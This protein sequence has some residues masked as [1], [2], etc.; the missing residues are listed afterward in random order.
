[1]RR[2]RK[3]AEEAEEAEEQHEADVT[4]VRDCVWD[5]DDEDDD[6][7]REGHER[8]EG[9]FERAGV[10]APAEGGWKERRMRGGGEGSKG[11]EAR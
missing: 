3:E 5:V 8:V 2:P 4:R 1:M 6:K 11:G 9:I 10:L 7:R